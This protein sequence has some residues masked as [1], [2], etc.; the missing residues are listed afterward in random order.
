[1][2]KKK[3]PDKNADDRRDDVIS[4]NSPSPDD[5][6]KFATDSTPGFGPVARRAAESPE[7]P[8]EPEADDDPRMQETWVPPVDGPREVRPSTEPEADEDPRL[9]DTWVP[10]PDGPPKTAAPKAAPSTSSED[11]ED[12]RLKDAWVPPPDGPPNA[13]PSSDPDGDADTTRDSQSDARNALDP[14]STW[15]PSSTPTHHDFSFDSGD[16]FSD[17]AFDD[18]DFDDEP[19]IDPD[20]TVIPFAMPTVDLPSTEVPAEPRPTESPTASPTDELNDQ[21][22]DLGLRGNRSMGAGQETVDPDTVVPPEPARK[23]PATQDGVDGDR[24]AVETIASVLPASESEDFDQ[25]EVFSKTVGMRNL[26]EDE[27]DEWQSE[28][29]EQHSPDT[30]ALEPPTASST[31]TPHNAGTQIWNRQSAD[32]LDASLVIRNRPVAGDEAFEQHGKNSAPDYDIVEKIAE[33]GM[34]A[35][36]LARQ[37][38]LDRE[39]A[40]KTLKPLKDREQKIVETQGRTQKVA[41]QRRE[42]FLSEALVTANLVHPHIIPIHDLCQTEDGAP[43]YS[44][45]RVKGIPWSDRIADMTLEENLEVLHKACDAM[46]Y[47]HHNGVVNRDLKPENIMLGEFGEVLVLD[48]GLAIPAS[49]ADRKRFVSPASPYG[50]GTP[51]YMSPELWSGPAEEIGTWSDIYLLGAILFEIVTGKP[52]HTFPK[53][54]VNAGATGLWEAIDGV[55]RINSIRETEVTGELLDIAMQAMQTK[56]GDRYASVLDFQQA[57]K[58]FQTHEES[59]RLAAKAAATLHYDNGKSSSRGYQNFQTAAALY[60]ESHNAWPENKH[61]REGLRNTRLAYATVANQNGDYDLGLQVAA[62]ESGEEFTAL[63]SQMTRAR[64]FRN[65]LKQVAVTAAGLIVIVGAVATVLA[66]Q[67]SQKNRQITSLH[68]NVEVLQQ[69]EQN[70]IAETRQLTSEKADLEQRKTELQQQSETLLARQEALLAE[71]KTLVAAKTL[72]ESENTTLTNEKRQLVGES[73]SLRLDKQNLTAEVM[74]V[75]E[76]KNA[77]NKELASLEKR[78]QKL[79]EQT[80]RAAVEL[81]S[82]SIASL[83]RNSD[84]S[85]ALQRIDE[86]IAALDNDPQYTTLPEPEREQRRTEL[87]ARQRLLQQ[88]TRS[89]A[90]PVQAQVISPSGKLMAWGDSAGKLNVW[91][92]DHETTEFPDAP[93]ASLN[94][95]APVTEITF[96]SSERQVI[97][98]AGS[99]LHLWRPENNQHHMITGHDANITAIQRGESFLLS[100]DADGYIKAWNADSRQPLWSIHADSVV[101]DLALLPQRGIFLYAGSRG[102]ESA[103][104][105]AYQLPPAENPTARPKRLGQLRFPRDRISPPLRMAV[106]PDEQLLLISNSRNGELLALPRRTVD[107]DLARDQFPFEHASDLAKQQ[108]TGWVFTHHMR[109]I[110]DIEFSADGQHIVTASDDRSIGIWQREE[111]SELRLKFQQR[112]E[113][114]GA[115]VNAAGFLDA[116]GATVVSAGADRYCRLWVVA[117]NAAQQQKI[118]QQFQLTKLMKAPQARPH[119]P[120]RWAA[121]AVPA[122]PSQ[123][124]RTDSATDYIVLNADQKLQRGAIKSVCLSDDGQRVVTGAADGTA[125]FWNSSTGKPL[126]NSSGR[127]RLSESHTAFAEGHDSN[128]ARMHFLPPDGKRLLTTGFDGNLCLWDADLNRP[129]TGHQEVKLPGLGLVNAVAVSADG[130]LIVT[131]AASHAEAKGAAANV[132]RTSDLQSNSNCEPVA[133]LQGFHRSEVSAIAV[134]RDGAR[135]ATGARDG[136]V[137]IWNAANGRLLAGGQAH[138]KNAIVSH[139]EWLADGR[140]FSAGFDGRLQLL[141]ADSGGEDKS[142]A[143][144]DSAAV[145]NLDVV[146]EF[147]HDNVPIARTAFASDQRRFLT[148]SARTDK[149]TKQTT[150]ELHLWQI[151]DP[152]PLRTIRPA[153]VGGRNAQRITS[154]HWADNGGRVAA[155]ID[156]NL[157][158]FDTDTWKI[159]TVLDAPQAGMAD[160]VFAPPTL[161]LP[162]GKAVDGIATFDGTSAHLWD[163]NNRSHL[164]AFRPMYAV[165]AVALSRNADHPVV[166]TGDR[167]IRIFNADS[168]DVDFA[169]SIFKVGSPHR[170]TVTSLQFA[171]QPNDDATQLFVSTGADRSAGLWRWN[172]ETREA[173]LVEKL[174]PKTGGILA[175]A[176][177]SPSGQRLLLAH[178]DGTLTVLPTATP[179]ADQRTFKVESGQTVELTSATFSDDKRVFAVAGRLLGSGESRAWVFRQGDDGWRAHCVVRGHDAGGINAIAFLPNS[180]WLV[181]GGADGHALVWNCQTDRDEASA[182]AAYEAYEFLKADSP[183][184]HSAPITAISVSAS[185]TVA[186]ASEDGTAVIWQMPFRKLED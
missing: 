71:Q 25:T 159:L 175:A 166:L 115:K 173:A 97:A 94:I 11:E 157:Q 52:P 118:E 78:Q 81:R 51:A 17:D 70:L 129:G 28:V 1:M 33:G 138:S 145:G 128:V 22:Q 5:D 42:M 40:I 57:V 106:S 49:A 55:V 164:A 31:G 153:V 37:T 179:Q 10:P 100:A 165:E 20:R 48:W 107:D 73:K 121:D 114:H 65:R 80:V 90:A 69:A 89:T 169:S 63:A 46:A 184:S 131:S 126:G 88:N 135:I 122:T 143:E 54:D 21:T 62:Q 76:Q 142:T 112:L 60:E 176:A 56:P 149:A 86:L 87:K 85:T 3:R 7:P 27:Y 19:A 82:T 47:A 79:A 172:S 99:S 139:L 120:V 39:L 2:G 95:G 150:D 136:R 53:P 151:G 43:Y 15:I 183:V 161:Q 152:E 30:V 105:L 74:A 156:G 34:G 109:P 119:I 130:Q 50:A 171:P 181:T 111:D 132:W 170:G 162:N 68:G 141:A 147:N 26:S 93:S 66:V 144:E 180:P 154:V 4:G 84:F 186:T 116:D 108:A 12:T 18:D 96:D 113:G 9:K 160:A 125:V 38:S 177:F 36:Y 182:F 83:V 163:L 32:G 133:V 24:R 123:N 134:G 155:V 146:F 91:K 137:A 8:A 185:G 44:M 13:S 64:S 77:V 178:A 101:R 61:A 72:L 127:L 110:N 67:L 124:D 168:T 92:I 16:G 29:A 174:Q 140:L 117:D 103:D 35:I 6:L 23:A 58:K 148:V 45:K 104:I 98:A 75:T 14:D 102:G 158:I 167:S 59:R 41:K